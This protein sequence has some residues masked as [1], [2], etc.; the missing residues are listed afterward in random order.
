MRIGLVLIFVACMIVHGW[1]ML[2]A[3]RSAFKYAADDISFGYIFGG[4][5]FQADYMLN[6]TPVIF[7]RNGPRAGN[8]GHALIFVGLE[9]M[10]LRNKLESFELFGDIEC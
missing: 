4:A 1:A 2:M 5:F 10:C 8:A 7:C 3:L 9:A 6:N